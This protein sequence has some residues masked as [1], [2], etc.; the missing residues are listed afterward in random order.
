GQVGAIRKIKGVLVHPAQIDRALQDHREVVRFQ[1]VVDQLP[2]ERYE[3]ATLR[4]AMAAPPA[5]A[6]ELRRAIAAKIKANILL[7]ME[8]ELVA[9]DAI[10]EEAGRPRFAGA[11]VDRRGK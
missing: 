9:L 7:Q 5:E 6:D 2:G 3:R 8:V 10:P 4:L 11:I 1:V